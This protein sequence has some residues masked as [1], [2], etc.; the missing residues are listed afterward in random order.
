MAWTCIHNLRVVSVHARNAVHVR[1]K[2]SEQKM[3][4]EPQAKRKEIELCFLDANL[5]FHP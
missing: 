5:P 2:A 4:Q 3:G 1:T